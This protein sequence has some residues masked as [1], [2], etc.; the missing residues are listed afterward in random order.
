[1]YNRSSLQRP[2]AGQGGPS[3]SALLRPALSSFYRTAGHAHFQDLPRAFSKVRSNGEL[4]TA[5][6]TARNVFGY[7]AQLDSTCGQVQNTEVLDQAL[8]ADETR[9]GS[10]IIALQSREENRS[11]ITRPSTGRRRAKP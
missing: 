4:A 8:E 3:P 5:W 11:H 9:F 7:G 10:R 6:T 1:M 2:S